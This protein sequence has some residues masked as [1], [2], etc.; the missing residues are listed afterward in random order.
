MEDYMSAAG[1]QPSAPWLSA[2][3]QT[4]SLS[5]LNGSNPSA[6]APPQQQ[7]QQQQQQMQAM[8]HQPPA[9]MY[10]PGAA[11]M[12]WSWNVPSVAPTAAAAQAAQQSA[13]FAAATPTYFPG[14][15]GF[16]A[17]HQAS[18]MP[19]AYGAMPPQAMHG[20]AMPSAPT[21]GSYMFVYPPAAQTS[22][23]TTNGQP[24]HQ[25]AMMPGY[26]TSSTPSW[27]TASAT[28]AIHHAPAQHHLAHTHHHHHHHHTGQPNYSTMPTPAYPG[29]VGAA[30]TDSGARNIPFVTAPA[31]TVQLAQAPPALLDPSMADSSLLAGVANVTS[32]TQHHTIGVIAVSKVVLSCPEVVSDLMALLEQRDFS[33]WLH[34]S[35]DGEP[36]SKERLL[37]RLQDD[38]GNR[39]LLVITQ[40]G[41]KFTPRI[42]GVVTCGPKSLGDDVWRLGAFFDANHKVPLT[43]CVLQLASRFWYAVRQRWPLHL[44][45]RMP[46]GSIESRRIAETAL[47]FHAKQGEQQG[48]FAASIE[49]LVTSVALKE[50]GGADRRWS[51]SLTSRIPHASPTK[52]NSA[53]ASEYNCNGSTSETESLAAQHRF[54]FD[55]FMPSTESPPVGGVAPPAPVPQAA[56]VGVIGR[57]GSEH[58][59]TELPTVAQSEASWTMSPGPATPQSGEKRFYDVTF[60]NTRAAQRFLMDLAT[61]GVGSAQW[62]RCDTHNHPE[63]LSG[64]LSVPWSGSVL[65]AADLPL[66]CRGFQHLPPTSRAALLGAK[67]YGVLDSVAVN[68]AREERESLSQSTPTPP[69]PATTTPPTGVVTPESVVPTVSIAVAA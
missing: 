4:D 9:F 25:T 49:A 6:Q 33:A 26:T 17:P 55:A 38:F 44:S 48:R 24:L 37:Q 35:D 23:A 51:Q 40:W 8:Q 15:A 20:F 31:P 28:G 63:F 61:W 42:S 7:Q 34:I 67:L 58:S 2:A 13:A 65:L 57:P 64:I 69:V 56:G 41:T 59:V 52:G 1:P 39:M 22:F 45:W 18:F 16:A 68:T 12:Q 36:M 27:V 32:K 53:P 3:N 46:K 21:A 19:I 11:P 14:T 66:S 10:M 54:A 62:M 30:G 29:P 43:L 50:G 60:T 47:V 5:H